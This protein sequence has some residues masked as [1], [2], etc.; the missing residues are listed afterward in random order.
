MTIKPIKLKL[1]HCVQCEH[2]WNKRNDTEPR[3]CPKC[4]SIYWKEKRNTK[5]NFLKKI[6]PSWSRTTWYYAL[7]I[8]HS[9]LMG[10]I[11]E[12]MDDKPYTFRFYPAYK[13]LL[14]R[15]HDLMVKILLSKDEAVLME[16]I[17]KEYPDI[18]KDKN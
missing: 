4:K 3:M 9:P 17:L 18:F 8:S 12:T 11:I 6:E 7:R 16:E 5:A 15:E 1:Y 2:T 13:I 14:K 10:D